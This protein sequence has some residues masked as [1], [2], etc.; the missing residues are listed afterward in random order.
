MSDYNSSE[1]RMLIRDKDN[2]VVKEVKDGETYFWVEGRVDGDTKVLEHTFQAT[3]PGDR[4][5][6]DVQDD[7]LFTDFYPT[8]ALAMYHYTKILEKKNDEATES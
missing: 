6:K 3:I 8:P 1:Q 2:N 7:K 5:I 4:V